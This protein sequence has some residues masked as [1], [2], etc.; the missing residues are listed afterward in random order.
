MDNRNVTLLLIIIEQSWY[1][2]DVEFPHAQNLQ[3]IEQWTD[4]RH[5]LSAVSTRRWLQSYLLKTFCSFCHILLA[6]THLWAPC[7]TW[8]HV[9]ATWCYLHTIAK[10]FQ[11]VVTECFLQQDQKF[12][13]YS[14][15]EVHR[16]FHSGQRWAKQRGAV[17]K[18][19]WKKCYRYKKVRLQL[20]IPQI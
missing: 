18:S 20:H 13:I 17:N 4:D 9:Y 7:S 16:S 12:Q 14:L 1:Q 2:F 15:L 6:H 8:K 10:A 19:R 11:A 5:T 3:L